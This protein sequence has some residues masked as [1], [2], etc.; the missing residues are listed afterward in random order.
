MARRNIVIDV[1]RRAVTAFTCAAAVVLVSCSRPPAG[2]EQKIFQTP[3]Q[4]VDGLKQAVA[5][6]NVDEVVAIFG[7]GGKELIDSADP[8]SARRNREVFTMAINEGWHLV[9]DGARKALVVGN[10]EWPFPVPLVREEPG[11]WRFDTAAGREEVLARRIGRNELAAIRISRAYVAA[12][13]RY[14]QQGHD[15][16]PAGLYARAFRSD[17][18]K[19]N[20]LYWPPVR[21]QQR[22]PLGDLLAAASVER[23]QAAGA[24]GGLTPFYG[25]YFRILTGQGAS[26]PGGAKDYLVNGEMSGGFA[27][28][29][30][31]AQYDVTGIMTFVVNQDGVVRETDLGPGTDATA[32]SL[33]LYDPDASWQTAE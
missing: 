23:R 19:Q 17:P 5:R 26:A 4:A 11:G 18:G 6:G 21:G 9:D 30:W 24:G 3:E 33:A 12:Q 20:G 28:V 25:Y 15:G 8:A 32:R 29:A 1:G 16:K 27:L 7:P 13:R 22:S 10:E 31:P 14:A 2:A